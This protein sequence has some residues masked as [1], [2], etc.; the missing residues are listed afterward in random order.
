M[1]PACTATTHASGRAG[2]RLNDLTVKRESESEDGVDER[3]APLPVTLKQAMRCRARHE[4][5]VR[6]RRVADTTDGLHEV[7]RVPLASLEIV[8]DSSSTRADVLFELR[9]MPAE[10]FAG[11][12][13]WAA[14][15]EEQV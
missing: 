2:G 12:R 10:G 11:Y 13:V 9:A 14:S 6:P 5:L 1:R 15:G 8:S 3:C 4:A 7:A